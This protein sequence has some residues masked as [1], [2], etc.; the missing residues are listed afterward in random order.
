[1]SAPTIK[2]EDHI[3]ACDDGR[4]R[5]RE[6]GTLIGITIHRIDFPER[7]VASVADIAKAF[8]EVPDA[9]AATGGEMPYSVLAL[10][11]G[12]LQQALEVGDIGPHARSYNS[13]TIGLAAHGDFTKEVYRLNQ[14]SNLAILTAWLC[15]YIGGEPKA[16]VRGHDERPGGSSDPT[17][18]CPGVFWP[19][20]KFR[21]L[22][23]MRAVEIRTALNKDGELPASEV[24]FMAE[25]ALLA[26]GLVF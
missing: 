1:M 23:S 13:S 18:K 12:R 25:K 3:Q 21:E 2:V 17:K 15:V 26:M 14:W 24:C 10:K 7:N 9:R 4:R 19:M 5:E 20:D 22:V 16:L 11:D 8:R 6:A